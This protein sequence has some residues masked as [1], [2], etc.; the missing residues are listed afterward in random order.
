MP[1]PK[2]NE[3]ISEAE[4]LAGEKDAEERHEYVNGQIHAMAGSSLRHNDIALNLAFALRTAA[5]GKPCRVNVSDVK[6]YLASSKAYYYPDVV[7]GCE[8]EPDGAYALKNPCL[9]AEVTSQSTQ[10]R[11]FT[12]KALAYQK[13]AS[14]QVYL[15][16]AQDMVEVT[17]YYRDAEGLWQVQRFDDLEQSVALVCIDRSV[18]VQEIYAGVVFSR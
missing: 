1:L 12:E 9:I 14:L 2:K 16:I 17:Q 6:V 5:Q 10:W 7:L 13:L 8:E 4:Y 15:V 11:D 3:F 18:T